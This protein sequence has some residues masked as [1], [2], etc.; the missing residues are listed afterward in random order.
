M[1][2]SS[3]GVQ[4]NLLIATEIHRWD[5]IDQITGIHWIF[6]LIH[7]YIA[8][9][10]LP[11]TRGWIWQWRYLGASHACIGADPTHTSLLLAFCHDCRPLVYPSRCMLWMWY[12][13]VQKHIQTSRL[14]SLRFLAIHRARPS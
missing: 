5:E 9:A 2:A 12:L 13:A 14:L 7:A 11:H 10:I 6:V 8:I 3:E 1:H 4:W